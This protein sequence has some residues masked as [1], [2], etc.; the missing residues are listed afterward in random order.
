MVTIQLKRLSEHV[1]TV[2]KTVRGT[3]MTLRPIVSVSMEFLVSPAQPVG[4]WLHDS[5]GLNQLMSDGCGYTLH[6]R[7][8]QPDMRI[9]V[10]YT[11]YPS[12]A[13][14]FNAS[15]TEQLKTR[16]LKHLR[17]KLNSLGNQR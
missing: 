5:R 1:G 4:D 6:R 16:A 14:P 15:T 3:L 7:F 2:K 13:N 10:K 8:G 12:T 11:L 9:T 17:T